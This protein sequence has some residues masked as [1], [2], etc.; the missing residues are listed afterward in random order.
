MK[1]THLQDQL[2]WFW[3]IQI[4]T[5]WI[6][7][8]ANLLAIS[9]LLWTLKL[10]IDLPALFSLLIFLLASMI[11]VLLNFVGG[12]HQY[13]CEAIDVSC[14][15]LINISIL[16]FILEMY[17]IKIKLASETYQENQI[18]SRRVIVVRRIACGFQIV[19]GS[20]LVL[21]ILFL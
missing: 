21:N 1:G 7:F 15:F 14:Q 2:P 6:F 19:T 11:H 12:E 4:Y 18:K 3:T 13:I 16:F 5:N 10:K 17:I 20:L 8:S 9:I